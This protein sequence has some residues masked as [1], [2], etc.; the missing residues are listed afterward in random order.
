M[1]LLNKVSLV[2]GAG[3]GIGEAIALT[4]AK[5]GSNV[6]ICDLQA[7]FLDK[8]KNKIRAEGRQVM[9]FTINVSKSR[10]IEKMVRSVLHK[11]GKIDILINNAA[12]HPLRHSIEEIS[13]EE[14]EEV[15]NVNLKGVFL[16][17][18]AV[19]GS[20]KKQRFGKIINIASGAGKTGGTIA[21][22][23]YSASKAG[24][25]CFTKSLA[26]EVGSFRI[27]VNAIAPGRVNTKMIKAAS[28]EENEI[29]IR[30][31]P[32]GRLGTPQ[33]IADAVL[34]LASEDS[35]FITGE[36][37]DVNGGLLMD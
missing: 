17:S 4:L 18:K 24:V 31:T 20:M 13:E 8:V 11:F 32:L 21:G 12:I 2:T 34:F 36:I 3:R 23:H 19:I 37:I 25:I 28:E 22:A 1:K 9:D 14:W 29:F 6:V 16:L 27:N 33:D 10:E 35:K 7:L 15:L 5:E 30:Q 26:K